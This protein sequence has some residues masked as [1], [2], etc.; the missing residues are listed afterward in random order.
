MAERKNKIAFII[1]NFDVGG[2]ENTLLTIANYLCNNGYNIH[3]IFLKEEGKLLERLDEK[4]T[5]W[6]VNN[7]RIYFSIFSIKKIINKISPDIIFPWMGFLNAYFIFFKT[8]FSKKIKWLCRESSIPSMMNKEYTFPALFNFFYKF[9]N[10][11]NKIICQS[12]YMKDDLIK[13]FHVDPEKI[14]VINNPVDITRAEKKSKDNI[15]TQFKK[16]TKNL[17]YVGGLHSWKRVA[18]LID[19]VEI[20]P[21]D[22]QLTIVGNGNEYQNLKEKILQKELSGRIRIILNCFNPY[23]YYSQA[24]CLLLCSEFEGFPNV[25][26]EAMALGCPVIGYNIKGGANEI[27]K[28]YG[29]FIVTGDIDLF[30]KKIIQ[31]CEGE[32]LDKEQIINGCKEKYRVEKIMDEYKKVI[33]NLS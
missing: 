18:L 15:E 29:G 27:L 14:T 16:S 3:I 26:I 6:N 8:L 5:R 24:H 33:D 17:L 22:Y 20:L 13:F 32:M 4:I 7:G 2:A 10:R 21:A 31:V 11:Y 9:Y 23:P 1:P 19:A 12:N 30:T 25:A 28:N